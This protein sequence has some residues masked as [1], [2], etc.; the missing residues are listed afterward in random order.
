MGVPG[1]RFLR[2]IQQELEPLK[3]VSAHFVGYICQQRRQIERF[4]R[5]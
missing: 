3:D 5:G 4:I 1:A 2:A